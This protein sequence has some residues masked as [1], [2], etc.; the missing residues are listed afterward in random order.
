MA[1]QVGKNELSA[2]LQAYLKNLHQGR[3][4]QTVKASPTCKPQTINSILRLC[5][6]LDVRWAVHPILA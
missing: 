3:A 2:Q 5:D 6:R 4:G 1:R